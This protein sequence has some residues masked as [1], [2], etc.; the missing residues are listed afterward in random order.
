M[1]K[2][3]YILLFFP[4]YLHAQEY[5]LEASSSKNVLIVGEPTKVLVN[6]NIPADQTIDTVFFK[7]AGNGDTL[8]NNWEL[9]NTSEIIKKSIQTSE[10]NY[11]ICYSQEFTIANFDTGK[12]E[13]PPVIANLDTTTLY[14]NSLLFSVNY[15]PIN[16]EESIKNL[17]PI[18]EVYISWWEY[19]IHFF[20]SYGILILLIISGIFLIIIIIKKFKKP[21]IEDEQKPKIPLEVTLLEK[22]ETIRKKKFWENG[23]YKTYYSKITEIIWLFLEYRYQI[24]TFEKTSD[25]II[26]SLKWSPIPEKYFNELS[27]LFKIADGV[28]FAKVKPLEKDNLHAF[29]LIQNLI[30][31]ERTD[32]KPANKNE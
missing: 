20:Y 10:N 24:Q 11:Y 16:Q 26:E 29:D 13:F 22:L 14:S 15:Q 2:L 27:R 1:S 3:L 8:G 4:I 31:E 21:I 7:L 17:K 9:W 18:K 12:Y 28:K 30:I 25:E 23:Y 5:K 32:L 6:L 19:I